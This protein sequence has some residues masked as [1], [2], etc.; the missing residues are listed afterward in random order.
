MRSQAG[1]GIK[2]AESL[3][4][5]KNVNPLLMQQILSPRGYVLIVVLYFTVSTFTAYIH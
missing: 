2:L 3:I 5:M 4:R 1:C